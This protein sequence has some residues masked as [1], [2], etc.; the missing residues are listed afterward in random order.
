MNIGIVGGGSIGLLSAALLSTHHNVTLYLRDEEQCESIKANHGITYLP[1][2]R[3]CLVRAKLIKELENADVFL[4]TVKSYQLVDVLEELRDKP[5]PI[6]FMQNGMGHLDLIEQYQLKQPIFL[7]TCE[8]GGRR[9]DYVSVTHTGYGQVNLSPYRLVTPHLVKRMR[10]LASE[11]FPINW[12]DDA[13]CLLKEKLVINAVINPITAIHHVQNGAILSNQTLYQEAKALTYEVASALK[14]DP[15]LQWGRVKKIAH[16]TAA[17]DSSMK[18]DLESGRLTEVDS[19]LG[20]F[21]QHAG[22]SI[23]M[24]RKYYAQIKEREVG[25]VK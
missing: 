25:G 15:K 24:I 1:D 23:P 19:I 3:H 4:L 10:M 22:E 5:W 8:H 12:L 6:V 13:E 14:M 2:N 9:E 18:V 17:N 21:I 11:L 20:Y 7:A 16:Q